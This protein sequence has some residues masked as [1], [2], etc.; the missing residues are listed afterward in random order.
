MAWL[1][2][3]LLALIIYIIW[4]GLRINRLEGPEGGVLGTENSEYLFPEDR[5]TAKTLSPLEGLTSTL[6]G[7]KEILPENR[8]DGGSWKEIPEKIWNFVYK[9]L[10]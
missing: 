3:I 1:A 7:L 5:E 10:P 6:A 8:Q 2:V 4:S 9:Y